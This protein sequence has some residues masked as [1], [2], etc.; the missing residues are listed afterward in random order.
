MDGLMKN[1]SFN[2]KYMTE[3]MIN[4]LNEYTIAYDFNDVI[5]FIKNLEENDCTV[6]FS[7]WTKDELMAN[8]PNSSKIILEEIDVYQCEV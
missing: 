2:K 6:K 7:A 3:L 8:Y 1:K 5:K 4:A